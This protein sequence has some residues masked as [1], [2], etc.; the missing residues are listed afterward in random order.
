M[1]LLS[2]DPI[3]V[4]GLAATL[5]EPLRV[6]GFRT[7]VHAGLREPGHGLGPGGASPDAVVVRVREADVSGLT[8]C[9]TLRGAADR[10]VII[11]VT[12]GGACDV[13]MAVEAGAD[14]CVVYPVPPAEL[15]ARLRAQ[16]RRLDGPTRPSPG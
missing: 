4:H 16:L 3:G 7:A 2:A 14:D 5:A 6:G 11:A 12:G 10:L 1:H 9:R 13:V 8:L 15:I